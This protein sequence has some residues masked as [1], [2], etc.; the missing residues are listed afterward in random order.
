MLQDILFRELINKFEF[1]IQNKINIAI[2]LHE[3]FD[4]FLINC[5]KMIKEENLDKKI[6]ILYSSIELL[7]AFVSFLYYELK[8]EKEK[9]INPSKN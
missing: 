6:S 9:T 2:E 7:S 4:S 1:T 3:E 5:E 8:N